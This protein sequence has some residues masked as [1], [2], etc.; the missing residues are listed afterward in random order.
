MAKSPELLLADEPT[1]EL[2]YETGVKILV[3]LREIVNNGKTVL[4]VTHNSEIAKIAD[5]VIE[6]F[7][8]NDRLNCY[9][10][11]IHNYLSKSLNGRGVGQRLRT[12]GNCYC[13]Q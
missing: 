2:D 4:I 8:L 12:T 6:T 10:Y 7:V 13:Y 11:G 1:G 5:I 3:L 9:H